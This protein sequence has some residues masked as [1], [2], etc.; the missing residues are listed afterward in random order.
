VETE[1]EREPIFLTSPALA[2]SHD[3]ADASVAAE[4]F[5]VTNDGV[6]VFHDSGGDERFGLA[7]EHH[8][9]IFEE[10]RPFGTVIDFSESPTGPNGPPPLVGEHT[11]R[12]IERL[13]CSSPEI[14]DLSTRVNGRRTHRGHSLAARNRQRESI[15]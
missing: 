3:L 5:V 7:A 2:W 9:S 12:I 11:P 10:L 15:A 13:D 4:V 8:R 1:S 6:G 14:E